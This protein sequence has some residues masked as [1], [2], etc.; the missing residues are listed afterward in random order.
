MHFIV[1]LH[2][3]G[4]HQ[5]GIGHLS[6]TS[7]L[8]SALEKTGFWQRVILLWEA[9]L[10]LAQHFIPPGC[11]LI[12]VA[13]RQAALLERSR[14][15]KV[16]AETNAGPIGA[17]LVTDLLNLEATDFDYARS[18]GYR[19]LVHLNDSGSGRFAADVLVD[20]DGFKSDADLPSSFQGIGRVGNAYRLIRPSIRS[21]RPLQ[22]WQGSRVERVLVTLGGA[23]PANLTL[24]LVRG[25]CHAN[26]QLPFHL[27]IVVGPAFDPDQVTSLESIN[28]AHS[29]MTLVNSP[30]RMGA[31]MVNHDVV[32]TL[33]GISTYEAL[34]LGRP[35]AAV[36]WKSMA[37]YVDSLSKVGLIENLGEVNRAP[38]VLLNFVRNVSRLHQLA[39]M[40][41][42][43]I[44]GNGSVRVANETVDLIAKA[45][46]DQL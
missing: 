11:K 19:A 33:G 28:K 39:Q 26:A 20:E 14:I 15:L 23:D 32:V 3:A 18:Q 22:P 45:F 10:T 41:W 30:S 44:D 24:E 25:L 38:H 42:T 34:C 2:A 35:C 27:T 31:F 37:L 17:V 46:K 6:R 4:N 43:S 1:V 16:E 29:Q 5:I 13:N 21:L 8:A 12:Q 9:D 36:S 7:T 40:G